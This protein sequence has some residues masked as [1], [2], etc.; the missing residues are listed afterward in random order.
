[1]AGICRSHASGQRLF[2]GK[3]ATYKTTKKLTAEV[4]SQESR[5]LPEM[6]ITKP[7]QACSEDGERNTSIFSKIKQTLTPKMLE[8]YA[9]S[10]SAEVF[11]SF[12]LE[13]LLLNADHLEILNCFGFVFIV[14]KAIMRKS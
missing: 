5:P 9:F 8:M 13:Q 4:F 12:S 1:M 2:S 10:L 14:F 6:L 7:R 3:E 11:S